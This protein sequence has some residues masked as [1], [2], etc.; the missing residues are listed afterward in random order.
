MVSEARNA[1]IK[2]YF[3]VLLFLMYYFINETAFIGGIGI[4]YRHLFALAVIFSAFVY[5]HFRP[6]VA[7]AVTSIKSALVFAVPLLVVLLSSC[8]VWIID[9]SD[10]TTIFRGISGCR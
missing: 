6:D 3:T 5:F 4:T 10:I 8:L 7:G 2:I 9:K 1:V